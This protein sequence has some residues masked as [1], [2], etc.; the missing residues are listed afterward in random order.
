[1][2]KNLLRNLLEPGDTH[3]YRGCVYLVMRARYNVT[4]WLSRK[5]R[6]LLDSSPAPSEALEGT[7][8]HQVHLQQELSEDTDCFYFRR[9]CARFLK[10][11][12]RAVHLYYLTAELPRGAFFQVLRE[13]S[14]V[15]FLS[16]AHKHTQSSKHGIQE[17]LLGYRHEH[18]SF[19]SMFTDFVFLVGKIMD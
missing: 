6:G 4:H 18:G 17:G 11:E 5:T 15:L 14:A 16:Q 3:V 8:S 12:D 13:T 2:E 9:C 10:P 7:K 1:M 19:S